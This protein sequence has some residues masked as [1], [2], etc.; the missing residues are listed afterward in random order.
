M[1]QSRR[2]ATIS[3]DPSSLYAAEMLERL[4]SCVPSLQG[5]LRLVK[6][7]NRRAAGA[8]HEQESPRQSFEGVESPWAITM[9]ALHYCAKTWP[10]FPTLEDLL[11]RLDDVVTRDY[12]QSGSPETY[13][14]NADPTAESQAQSLRGFLTY[15]AD[16]SSFGANFLY[17][18]PQS[19]GLIEI[20]DFSRHY[21]CFRTREL[22][23]RVD[24]EDLGVNRSQ[25]VPSAIF[26]SVF[27][28]DGLGGQGFDVPRFLRAARKTLSAL[29]EIE[30]D[31]Q[32]GPNGECS[33]VAGENQVPPYNNC[34]A[35]NAGNWHQG[36]NGMGFWG[37]PRENGQSRPQFSTVNEDFPALSTAAATSS[38]KGWK[39]QKPGAAP[40][41]TATGSAPESANK[42]G[43]WNN[44]QS[45]SDGEDQ[46]VL[47]L[48]SAVRALLLEP[49]PRPVGSPQN[50][51]AS[52]PYQAY[53]W[54]HSRVD[55]LDSLSQVVEDLWFGS[56]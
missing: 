24:T 21:V 3:L 19:G 9:L 10:G 18:R 1:S 38:K 29:R 52:N 41:P 35:G 46:D 22:V 51:V 5:F 42:T 56:D 54:G 32:T 44:V 30:S 49:P 11:Y 43:P 34:S 17:N 36:P 7:W 47:R 6:G 14:G 13:G 15:F 45:P 26:R 33:G 23:E 40:T 55:H 25:Q 28:D 48:K 12:S 50:S 16:S 37:S 39:S 4:C 53:N 31:G 27:V 20:F 8:V 2:L